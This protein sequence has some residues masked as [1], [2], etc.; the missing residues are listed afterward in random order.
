MLP[1]L[2]TAD[3]Q[4]LPKLDTANWYGLFLP[5]GT[6]SSVVQKLHDAALAALD[7]P[8]FRDRLRGLG[9]EVVAPER[10]SPE[11]LARFLKNDIAKWSVPIKASGI[12][13][14]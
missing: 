9:V 5:K 7:T 6:P 14:D 11:Y 4:G 3:E 2:R 8:S 10:R 13:V 12:T 1:D